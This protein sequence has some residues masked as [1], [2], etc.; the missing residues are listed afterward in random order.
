MIASTL[1]STD[2]GS[3]R[4][5]TGVTPGMLR[6]EIANPLTGPGDTEV[7][8]TRTRLVSPAGVWMF[9]ATPE[10]S[11]LAERVPR[12]VVTATVRAT[13]PTGGSAESLSSMVLTSTG[14]LRL[15]SS[16]SP[17]AWPNCPETHRVPGSPST[18]AAGE[19]AVPRRRVAIA[20]EAEDEATTLSTPAQL[21]V[22]TP[23]LASET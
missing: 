21:S 10:P 23:A 5:E 8:V 7:S 22:V 15:T 20:S 12:S 3:S 18:A 11:T 2:G 14:L 9:W 6:S 4:L 13:A 1:G 16:H 19:Y 17:T